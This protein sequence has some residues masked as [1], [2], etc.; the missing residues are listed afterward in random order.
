M[1]IAYMIRGTLSTPNERLVWARETAGYATP[2]DAARAMGVP[3]PTYLGHENG[4]GGR[5]VPK[6]AAIKYAQFF[7]VSLEWL[8]TKKG[9]PRGR[10]LITVVGYIGE[11][12]EIVLLDSHALGG[13]LEYVE[14]PPGIEFPCVAAR[15]RG[16]SMHPFEDGWLVFWTKEASGVPE[17]CIGKLCV[18]CLADGRMYMKRLRRGSAK[19]R[20]NLESWNAPT[21]ENA[22]LSWAARV[23]DVRPQ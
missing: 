11:R 17:D 6:D 23:I 9:V 10:P 2:T 5:D 8:L 16:D 12:A 1:Q 20:F 18:V 14:P 3:T 15:I 4:S 13:G 7:K 19:H 21:I 22:A